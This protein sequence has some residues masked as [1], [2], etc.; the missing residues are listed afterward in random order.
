M[1]N[2]ETPE[3]VRQKMAERLNELKNRREEERV[4]EVNRRLE[5]RFKDTTDD[6]RKEA[7]KFFVQQCQIEREKQL[8]DKKR[9]A[10]NK[11]ME[12]QVYA[13]LWKLDLIAKEERERKEVEE[14]KKVVN[15]TQAVLDWQ[16]DTRSQVKQQERQL[17][18]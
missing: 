14:K 8:M 10:E 9:L 18:D 3:Q 4:D 16:K 1:T 2:L 11:I 12:E 5:Q 15:D 17:T 6:L 13:Q 7:G